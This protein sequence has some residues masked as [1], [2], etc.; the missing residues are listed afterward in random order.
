MLAPKLETV[1]S[2]GQPVIWSIAA[3]PDGSFYVGT[4]HRGRVYRIDSAG[5]GNSGLDGRSAGSFR[6]RGGCRGRPL[7]RHFAGRK[8]VPHREGKSIRI[9]RAQGQVHLVARVC[10]RWKLVRGHRRAGERLPRGQVGK[11]GALL[12]DWSIAR[13]RAGV[14]FAWKCRWPAPNRTASCTA[15]ARATRRSCCTTRIFRKSV[16][17]FRCPTAPCMPRRWAAP[18]PI[19]LRRKLPAL[20]APISVTVTAPPTSI[21]VSDIDASRSGYQAESGCRP[22]Q[23]RS[24]SGRDAATSPLVEIPGVDKSALYKINPDSTVETLWSSKDEN[25]YSMV[26]EPDGGIVFATDAQGRV[27]RLTSGPQGDAAGGDQRRRSDAS[28]GRAR[29]SAGGHGRHGQALPIGWLGGDSS[30]TYESPVHDS[31]TVARWG[32]MS[33]RGPAGKA[34]LLHAFGKL[35]AAGQDLERL[36]AARRSAEFADSQPQCALHSVARRAERAGR[37]GGEREH[38]VPC[39][40]TIRRWFAAST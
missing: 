23:P 24:R 4:G 19:R 5:A 26:V 22:S 28:D 8:G 33:W 32:R 39:R 3:A 13:N 36:G 11:G 6:R 31:G 25:V 1:F 9:L 10:E 27:Y 7:R 12:R 34:E 40:R 21:T 14:R 38:R 35:R 37:G 2:S 16:P 29:R 15:S 18:S 17:S 20:A 30:G